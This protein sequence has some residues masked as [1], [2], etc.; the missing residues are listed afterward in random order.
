MP[1]HGDRLPTGLRVPSKQTLKRYG[2]DLARWFDIA[3][4]QDFVCYICEKVPKKGIL[5]VDHHHAKGWAKMQPEDRV[6]YV[7]GLLCFTCNV[8]L[9]YNITIQ[10]L[11]R[12]ADYLERYLTSAP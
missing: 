3:A 8:M 5:H 7:R 1:E 10:K 6:K 11:R 12:G 9:R 4:S 2:L